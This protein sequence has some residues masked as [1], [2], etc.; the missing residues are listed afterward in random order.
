LSLLPIPRTPVLRF[1]DMVR[2]SQSECANIFD[3]DELYYCPS[4]RIAIFN[5]L[6]QMNIAHDDEVLMP[7]YHCLSMLEPLQWIDVK[8]KFFSLDSNLNAILPS[9]DQQRTEKTKAMLM[10]HYFGFPSNIEEVREWCQSYKI[11]LIEDCSH[12]LIGK[13]GERNIGT[14]GD[15]VVASPRK[16]FP[17]YDGGLFYSN[18]SD[19]NDV[20]QSSLGIRYNIK[21]IINDIETSVSYGRLALFSPFF[22]KRRKPNVSDSVAPRAQEGNIV[23]KK[24]QDPRFSQSSSNGSVSWFSRILFRN[25]VSK[26]S[27][28]TRRD[29]Y[30]YYVNAFA[31]NK[32]VKSLYKDLPDGVMP[33]VF[34]L[35]ILENE[36]AYHKLLKKNNVPMFRWDE[37]GDSEC[38]VS[39]YYQYKLIQLP[40]HEGLSK[41]EIELIAN[42]VNT[43]IA[44]A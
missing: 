2:S 17:T 42:E 22:S 23:R 44:P 27:Y 18:E 11:A 39:K 24:Y 3:H 34:P 36:D 9:L 37:L 13:G 29:Y 4:G 14:F 30:Q 16:F 32:L 7:S 15:F 41:G 21:S 6:K 5:V 1:I 40:C 33:Y 31:E 8:A 28:E 19:M 26:R 43:L 38:E 25:G 12:A 10:V 20:S 35:V